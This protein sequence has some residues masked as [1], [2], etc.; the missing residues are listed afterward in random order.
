MDDVQQF[1]L[2]FRGHHNLSVLVQSVLTTRVSERALPPDSRPNSIDF[3]QS[4][5]FDLFLFIGQW[6]TDRITVFRHARSPNGIDRDESILDL[7]LF[8]QLA[9]HQLL[10]VPDAGSQH[11]GVRCISTFSQKISMYFVF[12]LLRA[13]GQKAV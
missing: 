1:V 10:Y 2:H 3:A 9:V 12:L 13:Y 5:Y 7:A 4:A 6:I 11:I 8:G